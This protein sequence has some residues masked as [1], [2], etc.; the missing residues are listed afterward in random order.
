MLYE[1]ITN[2]IRATQWGLMAMVKSEIDFGTSV[3]IP[4]WE[5]LNEIVLTNGTGYH[6]AVD[7]TSIIYAR[8]CWWDPVDTSSTPPINILGNDVEYVARLTT[9]PIPFTGGGGASFTGTAALGK[10]TA[11]PP[12]VDVRGLIKQAFAQRDPGSVRHLGGQSYN[13]V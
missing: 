7:G 11:S 13:F 6:A 12:P 9:D 8:Q 1:V 10:T 5:S 3:A 4:S 2:S